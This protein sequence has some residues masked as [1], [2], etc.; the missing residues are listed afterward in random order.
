M[1]ESM[2]KDQCKGMG[3]Q[4]FLKAGSAIGVGV[5]ALGTH[6]ITSAQRKDSGEKIDLFCHILPPTP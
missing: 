6:G 4:N 2:G 1:K 3:R 5:A